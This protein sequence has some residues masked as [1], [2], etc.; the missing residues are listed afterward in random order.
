MAGSV[1]DLRV[2]GRDRPEAEQ[3]FHHERPGKQLGLA[4][5][6]ADDLQADRQMALVREAAG[7][8]AGGLARRVGRRQ[9]ARLS[10]V[11]GQVWRA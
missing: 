11:A 10:C 7:D 4:A 2:D 9:C 3:V 1:G 6:R 8:R 5:R